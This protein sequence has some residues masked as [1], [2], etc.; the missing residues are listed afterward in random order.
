LFQAIYVVVNFPSNLVLDAYGCRAG[1]LIGTLLTT[2]GMILKVFINEIGF[3]G[4]CIT[5]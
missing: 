1:V 5:G 2:V 4:A 3:D